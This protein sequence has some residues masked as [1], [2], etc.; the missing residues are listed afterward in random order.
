MTS[1]EF[2]L[3]DSALY[4]HSLC[5]GWNNITEGA[6]YH[7]GNAILFL[8]YMGGSGAYG[9]LYIF[10]FLVPAFLCLALWGW[11]SVCGLDVFIWNLLLM[12]Q[13]LAQVCHL[14]F[15]LMR[16]G[17]AN[18]ELS[19]LYT[20]VYLPLDVPVQVFKQI[21]T[22][23]ENK[24]LSL[25]AEETYAVEGKTPIDQLSFLLS[26]RPTEE[27]NFQVTLTAET[28]CRYISWRRRRLYFLLSK[29]RYIARLFSVMLGSDIADKLYSLNDKLFAKSGVRLD[30][31]LPSLY[32][33][34]APSPQGSEG[35]SASS[36]PRGSLGDYTGVKVNLGQPNQGPDGR[37][38][39]PSQEK[40]TRPMPPH[41]LWA[42]DT[43]MPSGEDSTS[44]ILEDFADMTGSLMDYGNEREYLK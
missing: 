28:D 40:S 19:A 9:A 44:L 22:A 5:D 20:T 7:L 34:L 26:G 33:V 23:G 39:Q 43:E 24:V 29:D 38:F 27:G 21:A 31:R 41:Q 17:L 4:N 18:E 13:S 36:P 30:I 42:S 3:I 37:N 6:I 14:I 8:G 10:S 12:L 15:R 2:S 35:G 25:G 11:V 16:D 1:G 32:H